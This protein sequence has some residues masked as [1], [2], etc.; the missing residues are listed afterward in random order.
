MSVDAASTPAMRVYAR[1][2][3]NFV[4]TIVDE[5]PNDVDCLSLA[6]S[7]VVVVVIQIARAQFKAAGMTPAEADKKAIDMV[8]FAVGG[9][10]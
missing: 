1:A 2:I 5:T 8:A 3:E 9:A 10:T 7:E 6:M 4:H